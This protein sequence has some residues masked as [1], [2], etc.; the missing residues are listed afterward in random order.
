[1]QDSSIIGLGVFF[2][3][4]AITVLYSIA[5]YILPGPR[6]ISRA[7][8]IE[9]KR[10]HSHDNVSASVSPLY[11]IQG[12]QIEIKI[13]SDEKEYLQQPSYTNE[14]QDK[15]SFSVLP[16]P[17]YNSHYMKNESF[18][19]E[20][21]E[22]MGSPTTVVGIDQP[23]P[24]VQVMDD[25]EF[26]EATDDFN[27]KEAQLRDPSLATAYPYNG[28][29]TIP[30]AYNTQYSNQQQ[31]SSNNLRGPS[32]HT[33]YDYNNRDTFNKVNSTNNGNWEYEES[34]HHVDNIGYT[35]YQSEEMLNNGLAYKY[36]NISGVYQ[37]NAIPNPGSSFLF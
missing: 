36:E 25:D 26:R 33:A 7:A 9:K 19:Y 27:D 6:E 35:N 1:M 37:S 14:Y 23:I 4:V 2:L 24:S 28:R 8:I 12:Q 15:K 30:S 31:P 34:P 10:I 3:V 22:G 11:L 18:A 29:N 21:E 20:E 16:S 32:V 5:L 17:Q 13:I